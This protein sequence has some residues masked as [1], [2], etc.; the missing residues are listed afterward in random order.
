MG[1]RRM[2]RPNFAERSTGSL[3]GTRSSKWPTESCLLIEPSEDIGL[4]HCTACA[5]FSCGRRTIVGWCFGA[6]RREL[7]GRLETRPCEVAP[8]RGG[9]AATADPLSTS[10]DAARSARVG[11]RQDKAWLGSNLRGGFS[12]SDPAR[13]FRV[14]AHPRAAHGL[15]GELT[16]RQRSPPPLLA[17]CRLLRRRPEVS[18]RGATRRQLSSPRPKNIRTVAATR[19]RE[20]AATSLRT[21]ACQHTACHSECDQRSSRALRLNRADVWSCAPIE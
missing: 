7:G 11:D 1:P 3:R 12:T 21:S 18:A 16:A 14:L 5:A 2:Q 9:A 17:A 15:L 8:F 10:T 13:T 4:A 19:T 6:H 20:T